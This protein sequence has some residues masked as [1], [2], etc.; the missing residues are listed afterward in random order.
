M[1]INSV[2]FNERRMELVS[3]NTKT[4]RGIMCGTTLYSVPFEVEL[5]KKAV[6]K[7]RKKMLRWLP[8]KEIYKEIKAYKPK[9]VVVKEFS[10]EIEYDRY[11]YDITCM[12]EDKWNHNSYQVEI[13]LVANKVG[14]L[15]ILNHAF[16]DERVFK[17]LF[18]EIEKEY[19]AY[20][21]RK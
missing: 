19:M 13:V 10:G 6:E 7:V 1:S 5:L 16:F 20:K 4:K 12:D 3:E 2:T 9:E 8:D 15:V 14:V 11:I 18:G 17:I 21:K